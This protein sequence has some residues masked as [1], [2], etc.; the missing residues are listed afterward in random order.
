MRQISM[1]ARGEKSFLF[2]LLLSLRFV[3]VL[4][5]EYAIIDLRWRLDESL[6]FSADSSKNI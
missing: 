1:V 3:V 4:I 2:L 5:I 6:D